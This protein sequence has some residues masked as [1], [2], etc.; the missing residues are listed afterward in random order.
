MKTAMTARVVL[1][2]LLMVT[3]VAADAEACRRRQWR[4]FSR[5]RARRC[6]RQTN[7]DSRSVPKAPT[8]K[9]KSDRQT[10]PGDIRKKPKTTNVKPSPPP[11]VVP[12]KPLAPVPKKVLFARQAIEGEPPSPAPQPPVLYARQPI[13]GEPPAPPLL[14]IEPKETTSPVGPP[15]DRTGKL[16]L[17]DLYKGLPKESP[18]KPADAADPGSAML[19]PSRRRVVSSA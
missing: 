18:P 7:C 5:L 9:N 15:A 12:K 11:K 19:L 2:G 1:F 10:S 3:W 8:K 6:Q 13:D 17:D 14:R 16:K 4:L